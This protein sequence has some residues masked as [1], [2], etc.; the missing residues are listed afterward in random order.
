MANKK[1]RRT[2]RQVWIAA[3]VTLTHWGLAD[4]G[5]TI[6]TVFEAG[7]IF[8]TPRLASGATI[9]LMV[10]TGGGGDWTYWLGQWSSASRG[11]IKLAPCSIGGDSVEQ[12][13][14]LSYAGPAVS[15]ACAVYG[16]NLGNAGSARSN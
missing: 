13:Q 3:S 15:Y 4:A 7:H 8:A 14:P 5:T 10:D 16:V 11:L 9:R 1:L 12:F 2:L 6:P